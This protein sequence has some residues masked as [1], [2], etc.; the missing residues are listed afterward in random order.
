M[1]GQQWHA[2]SREPVVHFAIAAGLLF[3]LYAV[4]APRQKPAIVVDSAIVDALVRERAGILS[5]PL[6]DQDRQD[7]VDTYIREEILLREAYR[8]GLDRTPRIRTQ[9]IQLMSHTLAPENLKPSEE[10]LRRF[11]EQNRERYVRPA[12]ITLSQILV[13]DG[14][15]I[16]DGLAERLNAGAN[17]ADVS[18]FDVALGSTIRRAGAENLFSLFGR[19]AAR[20]VLAIGDDRWHGPFRSARGTHFVRIVERHA[21]EALTYEQVANYVAED[22]ELARQS[23]AVAREVR[24]VSDGYRIVRSP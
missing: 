12:S 13:V 20:D 1:P 22:W 18:D 4:V 10:E 21:A 19:D 8:R 9:L 23:E 7:V 16:P 2:L 17:P 3:G 11:F 5:R 24:A 6:T 14:R 15:P